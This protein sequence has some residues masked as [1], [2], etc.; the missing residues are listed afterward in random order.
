MSTMASTAQFQLFPP[1]PPKINTNVVSKSNRTNPSTPATQGISLPLQTLVK[2]PGTESVIIKVIGESGKIQP[3]PQ[4]RI[5]P[6]KKPNSSS[7][8]GQTARD[9][10][11]EDAR[12]SVRAS[13]LPPPPPLPPQQQSQERRQQPP[14]LPSFSSSASPSDSPPLVDHKSSTSPRSQ[15]TSPDVPLRSMFPT[16]NPNLPLSQ[17]QYYPQRQA[18]LQGQVASREEYSPNLTSPSV[19]DKVLGGAKTA[20]SSVL[21]FPMDDIVINK[22]P[23]SPPHVNLKRYGMQPMVT[24]QTQL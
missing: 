9:D 4:A 21:D 7:E 13:L 22:T 20:P 24:S 8:W 18:C 6:P 15:P 5:A 23:S 17:Q 2:S 12:R 11:D 1:P 19:L 3:L 16:Y 14:P 10:E